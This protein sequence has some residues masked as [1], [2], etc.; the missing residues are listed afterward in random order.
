MVAV[1]LDGLSLSIRKAAFFV[2]DSDRGNQVK[3]PVG[4]LQPTMHFPL[5]K[6]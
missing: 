5:L 4:A 2:P 1:T 6:H 3:L